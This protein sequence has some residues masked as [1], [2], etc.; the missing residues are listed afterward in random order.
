MKIKWLL[1]TLGVL[2]VFAACKND[3]SEVRALDV[4][5]ANI[6]KGTMINAYMSVEG[7]IQSHLTA[8]VMNRSTRD[9]NMTE[10]PKSLNVYL[11][12]DSGTK[13]ATYVFAKYGR[14]VGSRDL[15]LL[16]DSVVIYNDNKDTLR[17]SELYWDKR[18][19]KLY[20]SKQ[21]WVHQMLPTEQFINAKSGMEASSTN[22]NNRVFNDPQ[23]DS[24]LSYV[25]GSL[26]PG[27][28]H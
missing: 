1:Y 23:E 18:T 17:T 20:T 5:N 4:K 28:M 16:K 12:N 26:G 2:V 10:F 8:P 25:E 11:Y 15:V 21:V 7:R 24:F 3:L 14:Y 13:V 19:N 27:G 9:S 22:L 6:E